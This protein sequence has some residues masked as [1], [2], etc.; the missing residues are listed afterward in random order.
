MIEGLGLGADGLYS[1][2][3]RRGYSCQQ[4]RQYVEESTPVEPILAWNEVLR[5]LEVRFQ[6]N[7]IHPNR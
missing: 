6:L 7:Q 4:D 5:L 3:F 2:A 1:Q